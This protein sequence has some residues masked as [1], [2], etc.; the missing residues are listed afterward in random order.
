[1]ISWSQWYP[2]FWEVSWV[3]RGPPHDVKWKREKALLFRRANICIY[4]YYTYIYVI[5]V[6]VEA[7]AMMSLM[8]DKW[9][10]IVVECLIFCLDLACQ[11]ITWTTQVMPTPAQIDGKKLHRRSQHS[12]WNM[13]M[14]YYIFYVVVF[15]VPIHFLWHIFHS[16]WK[17]QLTKAPLKSWVIL[18]SHPRRSATGLFGVALAG[19]NA[20]LVVTIYIGKKGQPKIFP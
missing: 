11:I 3:E 6:K 18:P 9:L 14:A 19:A 7:F 17:N 2:K 12:G 4:I 1:M 10:T 15:I 13:C 5:Y 8:L 16:T 20:M